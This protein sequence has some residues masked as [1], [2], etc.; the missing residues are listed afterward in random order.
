M[1]LSKRAFLKWVGVAA[2]MGSGL[3]AAGRASQ[4]PV[5]P[6][7][8]PSDED[9]LLDLCLRDV[10]PLNSGVWIG[11]LNEVG[12]HDDE[13]VEVAGPGYS[14]QW[15]APDGWQTRSSRGEIPKTRY[16]NVEP[17]AFP[18]VPKDE[19][20]RRG[21]GKVYGVGLF[22]AETGGNMLFYSSVSY[23]VDVYSEDQF[24][25]AADQLAVTLD[26]VFEGVRFVSLISKETPIDG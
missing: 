11:L 25:F 8:D 16:S 19:P 18:K 1:E 15:V 6:A 13:H 2:G 14:R 20:F 12:K 7:H 5:L 17:I 9:Q 23:P 26:S 3:T 21:W 10:G 22:D 24:F 4:V